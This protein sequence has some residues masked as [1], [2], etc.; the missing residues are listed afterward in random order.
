M[1]TTI[2]RT[3]AAS[4]TTSPESNEASI[5]P[6]LL[7][8]LNEVA[9]EGI[10]EVEIDNIITLGQPRLI[11]EEFLCVKSG[12]LAVDAEQSEIQGKLWTHSKGVETRYFF[13]FKLPWEGD[14]PLDQSLRIQE[15]GVV[16]KGKLDPKKYPNLEALLTQ[17]T[18]N[19][20]GVITE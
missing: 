12:C 11:D 19:A 4:K 3:T 8:D 7:K 10:L 1:S 20:L 5:P 13:E 15:R 16:Y 6:R 2:S 9:K 14:S 17:K 18:W